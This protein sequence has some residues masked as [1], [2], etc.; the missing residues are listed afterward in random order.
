M[1]VPVTI[2]VN[3]RPHHREVEPRLLLVHFL[4]EFSHPAS[5]YA[6]VGAAAALEMADGTCRAGGA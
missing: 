5:R 3:G 4:Q 1:K 6:V 2:T